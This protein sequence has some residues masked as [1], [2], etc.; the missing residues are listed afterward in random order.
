MLNDM[1]KFGCLDLKCCAMFFFYN[2]LLGMYSFCWF[3]KVFS[4]NMFE[5]IYDT[6]QWPSQEWTYDCQTKH[7]WGEIP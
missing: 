7:V 4:S 1:K 5:F 6:L 3:N 2:F